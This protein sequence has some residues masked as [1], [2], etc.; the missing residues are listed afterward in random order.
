MTISHDDQKFLSLA[1][2]YILELFDIQFIQKLTPFIKQT[3]QLP[4]NHPILQPDATPDQIYLLLSGVVIESTCNL[5][6]LEKS[7]LIFPGYPIGINCTAHG[8]P[9]F[10]TS[11]AYVPSE[12]AVFK[13]RDLLAILQSSLPILEDY[14]RIFALET[15]YSNHIILQ[16]SACSTFLKIC[17]TIYLYNLAADHYP[18]LGQIKLTQQLLANLAGVHRTSVGNAIKE[19]KEAGHFATPLQNLRLKNPLQFRQMAFGE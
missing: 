3:V 7:A 2:F 17:Q 18:P 9:I 8:Q 6:G 14:L 5:N 10:Y 4:K 13:Y 19:L 16:N 15:R 1:P 11:A 12:V